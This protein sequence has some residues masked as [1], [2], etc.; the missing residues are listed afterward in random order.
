MNCCCCFCSKRKVNLDS[1]GPDPSNPLLNEKSHVPGKSV[2]DLEI[3]SDGSST[4]DLSGGVPNVTTSFIKGHHGSMGSLPIPDEELV[5][6]ENTRDE[7]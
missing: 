5:I 6:G 4:S 2:G 3:D 1:D 7:R